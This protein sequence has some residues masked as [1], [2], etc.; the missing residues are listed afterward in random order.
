MK[1]LNI[2]KFYI[3]PSEYFTK[4]E[5]KNLQKLY[6]D[7]KYNEYIYNIFKQVRSNINNNIFTDDFYYNKVVPIYSKTIIDFKNN[8]GDL[9]K[10]YS[11]KKR[12]NDDC[13]SIITSLDEISKQ[14]T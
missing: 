14:I 7:E 5:I 13:I 10:Y 6:L 11:F 12:V 3:L 2:F 4:I 8:L 1:L 9:T